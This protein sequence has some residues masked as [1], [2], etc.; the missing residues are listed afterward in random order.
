MCALLDAAAP[1]RLIDAVGCAL[2]THAAVAFVATLPR[3]QL[4]LPP[5]LVQRLPLWFARAWRCVRHRRI[6]AGELHQYFA[7]GTFRFT[8]ASQASGAVV[9]WRA[10]PARAAA[11][12]DD[13]DGVAAAAP[14][15]PPHFEL[16]P[17]YDDEAALALVGFPQWRPGVCVQPAGARGMRTAQRTGMMDLACPDRIPDQDEPGICTGLWR[18]DLLPGESA[19]EEEERVDVAPAGAEDA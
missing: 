18:A 15:P 19:E 3:A 13:E 12:A 7:D 16:V 1:L 14:A 11:A 8:R 5:P 6:A 10:A 2:V 9:S 4:G 17:C